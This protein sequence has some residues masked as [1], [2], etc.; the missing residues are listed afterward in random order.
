METHENDDDDDDNEKQETPNGWNLTWLE[1]LRYRTLRVASIPQANFVLPQHQKKRKRK[2]RD[3]G[4]EI[5]DGGSGAIYTVM[6][7][8]F[9]ENSS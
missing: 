1:Q 7:A 9:D 3:G 5:L 8:I 6:F 2:D 4:D